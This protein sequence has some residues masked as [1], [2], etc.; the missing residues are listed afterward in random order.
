MTI[1][2]YF[3]VMHTT[4]KINLIFKETSKSTIRSKL[5]VMTKLSIRTKY[6]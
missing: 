4:V 1:T 3:E 5:F 2:R 6:F